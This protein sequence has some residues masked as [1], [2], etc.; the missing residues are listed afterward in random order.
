MN[1]RVIQRR[2]KREDGASAVEYGLLVVA[3]AA[4]IT[5]IVFLLGTVVSNQFTGTCDSIHQQ[6]TSG[7]C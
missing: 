1:G 6:M 7:N 3:I 5:L 4:A 2:T